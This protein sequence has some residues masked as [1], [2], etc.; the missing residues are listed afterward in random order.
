[1]YFI[2]GSNTS[3][4]VKKY[5]TACRIFNFF[6]SVWSGDEKLSHVWY[7]TSNTSPVFY[8][9]VLLPELDKG[10]QCETQPLEK[11]F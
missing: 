7:I 10:R 4:F 3:K 1:M 5:S 2:T 6:L 8:Q 9:P 11:L